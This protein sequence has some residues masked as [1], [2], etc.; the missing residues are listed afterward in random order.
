M[1]E[2]GGGRWLTLDHP[3]PPLQ[4]SNCIGYRVRKALAIAIS[5]GHT[6]NLQYLNLVSVWRGREGE[7]DDGREGVY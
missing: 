6:S 2:K 3:P 5:Q 1:G 4:H 7:G